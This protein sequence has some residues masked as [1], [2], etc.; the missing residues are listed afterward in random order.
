MYV[1]RDIFTTY[2]GKAKNLVKIFKE[3]STHFSEEDK[4]KMRIMTDVVANYWT[5]VIETEVNELND[6]FG[7]AFGSHSRIEL[8]L[9]PLK[10]QQLIL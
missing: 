7:M 9:T 5:V 10:R 1:I 3:F 4:G 8:P 6:Y 2:P